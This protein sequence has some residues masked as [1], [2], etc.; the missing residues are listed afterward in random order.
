MLPPLPVCVS[1]GLLNFKPVILVKPITL[2]PD[3]NKDFL[4]IVI[5]A[6]GI[7]VWNNPTTVLRN[8]SSELPAPLRDYLDISVPQKSLCA[9]TGR[10][11][12]PRCSLLIPRTQRKPP[13]VKSSHSAGVCTS[14][15]LN[16]SVSRDC[17]EIQSHINTQ[18]HTHTQTPRDTNTHPVNTPS[19][20]KQTLITWHLRCKSLNPFEVHLCHQHFL[21]YC[22]LCLIYV[23]HLLHRTASISV[24]QNP[25]TGIKSN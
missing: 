10:R 16:S 21:I 7:S 4:T 1:Y 2:L 12:R 15:H 13:V 17:T 18:I 5:T 22:N 24:R 9:A 6:L 25:K 11:N 14:Y 23:V 19:T 20:H 8:Y 3:H